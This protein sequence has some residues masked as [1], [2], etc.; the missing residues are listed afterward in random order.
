MCRSLLFVEDMASCVDHD[1]AGRR[2][3]GRGEHRVLR[4][5]EVFAQGR[6][7]GPLYTQACGEIVRRPGV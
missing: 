3:R 2:M 6:T 7:L 5:R 1:A 4:G